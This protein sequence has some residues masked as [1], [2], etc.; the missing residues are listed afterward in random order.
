MTVIPP[1]AGM[2]VWRARG[3]L[4]GSDSGANRAT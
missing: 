2:T 1:I 4:A 3:Q